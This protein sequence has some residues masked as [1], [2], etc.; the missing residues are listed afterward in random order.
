MNTIAN[1]ASGAAAASL[2]RVRKKYKHF[3]LAEVNL[4]F[5]SGEV[6]GLIGPNG[7]GK[8]TIMRMLMGFVA[9]DAGEASALGMPMSSS[10]A[11]AKLSIGY[12][13]EEMRLYK[14]ESLAWH[15]QF[16][17]SLYPTWDE[18][19]ARELISRFG[20]IPEQIMKGVSHGQ[21]VKAMLLLILARRPK[22]LI[23]DEP[24]NGLDPVAKHE[25][26]REL[27]RVMED[28]ERTILYS[29]HNTKDVEQICDAITFIDR[30][31]VIASAHRDEFLERWRRLKVRVGADWTLPGING[32]ETE[33]TLGSF[34]VLLTDRYDESLEEQLKSSGVEIESEETLNL[35]DIFVQSVRRGREGKN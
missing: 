5:A 24:T 19:Y 11:L 9:P 22:L 33:S 16:V 12:F 30:G 34:R 8:S 14:P 17:R 7:A 4:D 32:L 25:V 31:R 6:H 10:Q 26:H 21:R 3:E 23:L 29:S 13:S 15:M 2:H 18:Q 20:L 28:E 27:M 35:E 1:L